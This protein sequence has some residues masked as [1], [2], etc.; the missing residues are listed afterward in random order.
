MRAVPERIPPRPRLWLAPTTLNVATLK[1]SVVGAEGL[2]FEEGLGEAGSGMA[3]ALAL[4]GARVT[5]A[6]SAG[7]A[8]RV[9]NFF[10]G[11]S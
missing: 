11:K 3:R 4:A 6:T 2:C 7:A 10:T 8:A 5:A 1:E 9:A